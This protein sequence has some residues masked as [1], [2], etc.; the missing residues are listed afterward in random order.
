MLAARAPPAGRC[1]RA[2]HRP[3]AHRR[4]RTRGLSGGRGWARPCSWLLGGSL[5]A[6]ELAEE[7]LDA[8]ASRGVAFDLTVPSAAG[9]IVDELL[10]DSKACLE[11]WCVV[12]GGQE[13]GTGEHEVALARPFR[14]CAQAVA[15]FEFGLEK[16]GL[17]P[18]HRFGVEAVLT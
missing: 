5:C 10:F 11:P 7:R 4:G 16:V 14:R 8:V 18:R 2:I 3:S 9:R 13:L 17:Q 1:A 6:A 12:P 15:E